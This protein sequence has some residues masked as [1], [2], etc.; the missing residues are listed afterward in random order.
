[1]RF[2]LSECLE[3]EELSASGMKRNEMEGKS[4]WSR[5][6]TDNLFIIYSN[7]PQ[8]SSLSPWPDNNNRQPCVVSTGPDDDRLRAEKCFVYTY[9]T[10]LPFFL[11]LGLVASSLART[12]RF[13]PTIMKIFLVL[14][15]IRLFP[16][17]EDFSC[18]LLLG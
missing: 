1:V 10:L 6:R 3:G 4:H 15:L 14:K 18:P 2:S 17:I 16:F 8:I 5:R 13:A 7:V 11:D 9:H 12:H